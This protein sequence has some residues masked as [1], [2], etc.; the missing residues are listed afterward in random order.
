MSSAACV[1]GTIQAFVHALRTTRFGFPVIER[2]MIASA[3][4][5]GDVRVPLD[6]RIDI[7]FGR[8]QPY[9]TAPHACGAEAHRSGHLTAAGDAAS[10]ASTGKGFTR[11]TTW[12]VR[13]IVEIE[14]V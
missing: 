1:F 8:C 10:P 9:R 3:D 14:P 7:A 11:S 6:G 2:V 13:T 12:G 4:V 5:G